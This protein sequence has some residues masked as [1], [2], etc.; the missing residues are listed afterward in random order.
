MNFHGKR[1]TKVLFEEADSVFIKLQKRFAKKDRKMEIKLAL[2]HEGWEQ[3]GKS[4]YELAEKNVICGIESSREFAKRK[5]AMISKIYNT[6]EIEL[7]IFNSDGSDWIKTLYE[8]DDSVEFQLDPFHVNKAIRGCGMGRNFENT[9]FAHLKRND[10]DKAITY[11]E[12][13]SK[14][15]DEEKQIQKLSEIYRYLST[16][17]QGLIPYQK[18]GIELPELNAGLVYRDKG[19]CEHNVYLS[20]AKRMK[21]RGA[22]WSPRGSLNICKILYMQDTLLKS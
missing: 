4:R 22:A 20:V 3:S 16:N 13:V 14:S 15:V 19:N 2:F 18:R 1:E 21:H 11:I 5:E 6:D 10:I 7:R 12:A 17:K 9:V 8:K